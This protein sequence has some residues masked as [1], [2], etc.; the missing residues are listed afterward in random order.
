MRNKDF[1]A[2]TLFLVVV[3]ATTRDYWMFWWDVLSFL[4]R[5]E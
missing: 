3:I 1:L 2:V 5:M 4:S